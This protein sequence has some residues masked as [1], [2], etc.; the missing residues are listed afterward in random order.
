MSGR[1]TR[2]VDGPTLIFV[3]LPKTGGTTFKSILRRVYGQ[4]RL[5]ETTPGQVPESIERFAE[6]PEETRA[7]YRVVTGHIPFGIET[8]VPRPSETIILLREPV[9]RLISNY[10]H[11][12]NTPEHPAHARTVAEGVSLE[13]FIRARQD[14]PMTRW[15]LST[16]PHKRALI[17]PEEPVTR[18][19]LDLALRNI[20][21]RCAVVGV[22][23]RFD[24]WVALV[25]SR[26]EWP[27]TVYVRSN[28]TRKRPSAEDLPASTRN[29]LES[30]TGFDRELYTEA[31]AIF[32]TSWAGAGTQEHLYARW[33]GA[34]SRFGTPARGAVQGL[35]RLVGGA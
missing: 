20:R 33:L 12:R 30:R 21:E 10:Y 19:H 5:F 28:V 7:A 32:E 18:R 4:A 25:A 16:D 17:S 9:E 6:L 8:L 11:V 24:E 26:F 29:L 15:Y 31:K 13:D 22:T 14:N 1:R 27:L 34:T 2:V 23:E 35:R 3:H